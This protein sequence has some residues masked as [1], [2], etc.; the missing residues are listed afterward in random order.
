MSTEILNKDET[1]YIAATEMCMANIKNGKSGEEAIQI[2]LDVFASLVNNID[3]LREYLY[4]N[5]SF[6]ADIRPAILYGEGIKDREWWSKY[7]SN[8][9]NK[10]IYWKR[11]RHYLQ[12]Y[13]KWSLVTIG[14][15]IETPTDYIMNAIAN[16]RSGLSEKCYGLVFGYVQSGKT[17]NYIGLINKAV[18]AGYKIIIVLAGMHNNLRSQTQTRIDEEVLGFETSIEYLKKINNADLNS[19]SKIGVGRV[20]MKVDVHVEPLTS[21]D[22]KGDFNR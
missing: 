1:F 17:A 6:E 14:R 8:I 10:L 22:E 21:R 7:K 19:L 16:P 12:E 2:T 18:D 5:I 11:Y 13:K 20:D 3:N 15:S 9:D 4:K